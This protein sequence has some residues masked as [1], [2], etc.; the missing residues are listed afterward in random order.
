MRSGIAAFRERVELLA[1]CPDLDWSARL[2]GWAVLLHCDDE[3]RAFPGTAVLSRLTGL[4]RRSVTAARARLAATVF[5]VEPGK[6]DPGGK[7][8]PTVYLF[9]ADR[10]TGST[11]A[12]RAPVHGLLTTGAPLAHRPVHP[13]HPEE[14]I[15]ESGRGRRAPRERYRPRNPMNEAE[16]M[17]AAAKSPAV[18]EVIRLRHELLGGRAE[19]TAPKVA[20]VTRA[21]DAGFSVESIG[22]ALRAIRGAQSRERDDR[23]L[24]WFCAHRNREFGYALRPETLQKLVDE[25]EPAEPKPTPKPAAAAPLILGPRKLA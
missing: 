8:T 15:E 5:D 18:A 22:Q 2:V 11:G 19:A 14:P 16:A 6:S 21:L 10:C 1:Q 12:P 4:C 9:R 17:L 20:A 3:G 25:A 13:V 7:R 24:A 23:S